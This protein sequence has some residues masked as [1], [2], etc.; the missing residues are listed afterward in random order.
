MR[1]ASLPRLEQ[2]TNILRSRPTKRLL[3][4]DIEALV[5]TKL[6]EVRPPALQ[7]GE[8]GLSRVQGKKRKKGTRTESTNQSPVSFCV[9]PAAS[10]E[11]WVPPATLQEA[12][13]SAGPWVLVPTTALSA[14]LQCDHEAMVQTKGDTGCLKLELG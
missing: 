11:P 5:T 14:K 12:Q 8:P 9:S 3:A 6:C 7:Q 13:A 4:N 1:Q 2:L 10:Q